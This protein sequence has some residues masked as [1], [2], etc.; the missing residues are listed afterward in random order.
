MA[1]SSLAKQYL[2]NALASV[3]LG[4]EVGNA[5]DGKP[6]AAGNN[7]FAGTNAF[8]AIDTKRISSTRGT[9]H[10]TNGSDYALSAGWGNTATAAVAVGS[11]DSR[12]QI[13][14]TAAGTG[15]GANPTITLTF[16]DGAWPAAP[17]ALVCRVSGGNQLAVPVHVTTTTTTLVVTFQGTPA[18][19]DVVNIFGSVEG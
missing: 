16:K 1:L 6:D 11:N 15:Q 3:G 2:T 13:G 5:I 7:T 12:F 8:A 9:A 19:N 10:A 14:V 17:F 4:G 18:A